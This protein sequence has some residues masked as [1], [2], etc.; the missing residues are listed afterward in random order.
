[1][2]ESHKYLAL[3]LLLS[4]LLDNSLLHHVL[5]VAAAPN[6]V[7]QN[8]F[9]LSSENRGCSHQHYHALRRFPNSL[10]DDTR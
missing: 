4:K 7:Y 9:A 3:H 1:M 5:Q 2:F 10:V 6:T 8:T